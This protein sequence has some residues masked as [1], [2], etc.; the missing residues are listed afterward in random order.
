MRFKP[1]NDAIREQLAPMRVNQIVRIT[2]DIKMDVI[3]Y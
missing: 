3:K 2:S 1:K